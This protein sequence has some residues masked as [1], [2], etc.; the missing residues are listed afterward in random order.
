MRP[1][2]VRRCRLF[3]VRARQAGTGGG[4]AGVFFGGVLSRNVAPLDASSAR[5][6]FS[7]VIGV[8]WTRALIASATALAIAGMTGLSGPWPA[9]FAP[10]GPSLSSVSMMMASI[11]GVS[12][13]VSVL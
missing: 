11:G 4:R 9:S 12:R 2:L 5:K 6:I 13:L 7:D 1:A 3:I 8:E 10:K